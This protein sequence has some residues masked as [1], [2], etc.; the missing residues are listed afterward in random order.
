MNKT[1]IGGIMVVA[2][3]LA[4]SGAQAAVEDAKSAGEV[5]VVRRPRPRPT[6]RPGTAVVDA[7][8]AG[9]MVDVSVA[10]PAVRG[11]VR[12]VL[13]LNAPKTAR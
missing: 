11:E 4:A 8:T 13:D 6:P 5:I 10:G 3:S 12:M 9:A 1:V 2:M 7:K